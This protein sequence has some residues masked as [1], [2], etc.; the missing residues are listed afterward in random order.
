VVRS[1]FAVYQPVFRAVGDRTVQ[2]VDMV[3]D[4]VAGDGDPVVAGSRGVEVTERPVPDD[5]LGAASLGRLA[6]SDGSDL[7][8]VG[9]A[10]GVARRGR[11]RR[12]CS[13][14]M[15]AAVLTASG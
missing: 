13:E 1:E 2:A 8:V 4:P 11:R 14:P 10:G 12:Q 5:V 7:A 15:S 6:A 9:V 3:G